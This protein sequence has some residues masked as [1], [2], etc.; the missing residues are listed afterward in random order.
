MILNCRFLLYSE[1][2]ILNSGEKSPSAKQ[3]NGHNEA[4]A[5]VEKPDTNDPP[6]GRR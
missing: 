6:A 3:G 2:A 5:F 4:E 1:V